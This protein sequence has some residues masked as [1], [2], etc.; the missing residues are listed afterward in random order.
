MTGTD[1]LPGFGAFPIDGFGIDGDLLPERLGVHCPELR[2]AGNLAPDE[3]DA[4]MAQR[5]AYLHLNRWT[6]LGL[7]LLQAM[8]LGMPVLVLDTTEASRAVP[9]GPGR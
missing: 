8:M 1:L 9:R 7:S 2:F 4:A 5:R 6:S 3:L